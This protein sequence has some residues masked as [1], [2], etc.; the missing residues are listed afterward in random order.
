[1]SA[2][3]IESKTED[4]TA[5]D[6]VEDTLMDAV[7]L[8]KQRRELLDK[9]AKDI[10]ERF[11]SRAARR[12]PKEIDW[13]RARQL[14]NSPLQGSNTSLPETPFQGDSKKPR[15]PEPNIVRT[16]CDTAIANCV[17]LQFAAGEKNWDLFPPANCVDPAQITACHLM[18]KEIETQLADSK[19]GMHARRAME[20][21]VILGTGVLKGPV[22]TGK[23]CVEYEQDAD[24]T[25][26][27]KVSAT[28]TPKVEQVSLWRFYP[29]DSVTDFSESEDVIE[30]HPMT[31]LELSQYIKHPGFDGDAIKRVLKGDAMHEGVKPLDY[32]SSLTGLPAGLW[33]R[34]P[35]LYKDRYLVLE[36]H[37]PVTYDDLDKLGLKPTYD[38]PTA[39][40]Y[41]EVWVCCGQVIRME[42][43]NIE[44]YYE[45]PYSVSTWKRDPAS[46]FGFGHPLLL[47][48]AQT[49]VTSAYHMILDN[50]ALTSG[51][52]VAMYQK[53]IQPVDGDWMLYPNKVWLLTDPTV[54]VNQA[55][56]FFNPTNVIQNIMPVLE[57]ARQFADEES[58]TLAFGGLQSPNAQES[59]TGA[60][61]MQHASTTLLD[62]MAEEWDD[63][64]TEKLIRR[65][66]A[67]NMQYSDKNEIK[68]NYCVD[69]KSA[70]EYKNKQLY[71]RDLE[72]LQM[73]TGQNPEM[74][75]V[76]NQDE[77]V[78]ARLSLM[79]L[80]SNKIVKTDDE[81][82]KAQKE[83]QN[84][85]DPKM[86]ELQ[87]KQGQL[88]VQ[89]AE[90]QLKAKQLQFQSGLEQLRAQWEHEEKMGANQA[91]LA[92]ANASVIKAQLDSQTE[93]LKLAQ[94]DT[95]M[96]AQLATKKD[97][98]ELGAQA[99]IFTKSMEEERK[100]AELDA[101]N[102]ELDLKEKTGSGI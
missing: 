63:Q 37:G 60:L 55:I 30:V 8:D 19:Y 88:R 33:E 67:W 59:A 80:P 9:L 70:S 5:G 66:Y 99:N 14:Y 69:V 47:Q 96:A 43:E 78:K 76:I 27:P 41:G 82:L 46:L 89:Q 51:P 4:R 1:M 13:E 91:R 58:A 6:V 12:G 61:V 56:Q 49:V 93:A 90:V 15:R 7:V 24:G 87:I 74:A 81:I 17:S 64:V 77:L 11:Q 48:D 98:A 85:P 95:H 21:R 72:R 73:E 94:K 2:P 50:A 39:Q 97:V 28:Y 52:Q 40:Y 101:T 20:D 22:N 65:M 92:E 102:R 23:M 68:G 32:N 100:Q 57:L 75:L 35:Y 10:E 29:D 26:V 38:S 34:N 42:L 71:I 84:K 62:F 36:Y 79:H 25:W 86:L 3:D 18:S 45:T 53:Y 31:Q 16:K 44:G 54:N 83:A